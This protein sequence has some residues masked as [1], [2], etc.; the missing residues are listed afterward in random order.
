MRLAPEARARREMAELSF[1]LDE[2]DACDVLEKL[3]AHDA[4]GR[5]R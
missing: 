3:T 4:A 5:R 2:D 1:G